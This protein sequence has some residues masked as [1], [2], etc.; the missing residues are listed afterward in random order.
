MLYILEIGEFCLENAFISGIDH[1]FLKY[2][3]C[4]SGI[5][6]R[7]GVIRRYRYYMV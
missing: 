2:V 4:L 7:G 1:L 3:Y 5:S 6:T